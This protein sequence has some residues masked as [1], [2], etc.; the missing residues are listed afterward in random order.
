MT[1][2]AADPPA[3][4]TAG[5][6]GRPPAEVQ[7]LGRWYRIPRFG[8][9][10]DAAAENHGA[11]T[12]TGGGPP[13]GRLPAAGSARPGSGRV[14][15]PMQGTV[16]KVTVAVGDAVDAVSPVVIL[17]AMKMENTLT[18]G[19]AGVVAAIHVAP[20]ATVAP[21]TLLVEVAPGAG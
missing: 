12:T 2:P 19:L 3:G 16:T 21:G 18:A 5:E 1:A 17:E 11:P 4:G 10:A 20:G 7:L 6:I 8:D 15:A 13:R 14:V 9:V